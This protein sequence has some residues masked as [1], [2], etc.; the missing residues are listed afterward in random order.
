MVSTITAFAREYNIS[1]RSGRTR[2]PWY[3]R[4]FGQSILDRLL[5][6]VPDI[7]VLVVGN[8]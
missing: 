4:W 1:N 7:D 5:N 2:R 8:E 3:R 6:A